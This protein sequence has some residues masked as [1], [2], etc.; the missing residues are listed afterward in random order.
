MSP[1]WFLVVALFLSL[2]VQAQVQK[3]KTTFSD[4]NETEMRHL[5]KALKVHPSEMAQ[6]K[7]VLFEKAAKEIANLETESNTILPNLAK[8][9]WA[10]H[11]PKGFVPQHAKRQVKADLLSRTTATVSCGLRRASETDVLVTLPAGVELEEYTLFQVGWDGEND[12]LYEGTKLVAFDGNDVY[13][14]GLAYYFEDAYVKG[15][16]NAAGQYVFESGQFVG[17]DEY[18]PEYLVGVSVGNDNKLYY[19]TQFV[20]DFNTTT[21]MLSLSEDYLY[22]ESSEKESIHLWDYFELVTYTP[23]AY[24]PPTEVV[25]PT[26]L[27]TEEY[28]ITA[29]NYADD[30][31]IVNTIFIGFEGN[32][33]YLRGMASFLPEA[34]IKGTLNGNTI[35][36]AA[37]QY[38]GSYSNF[39]ESYKLYLNKGK[40]DVVFTYDA[41]AGKLT[42]ENELFLI[43]DGINYYDAYRHAVIT[44]TPFVPIT[45]PYTADFTKSATFYKFFVIDANDDG[46]TW[47]W[48]P[49]D[50]ANYLY[51]PTNTADDYLVLPIE[52]EANKNYSVTVNASSYTGYPDKFE[53]KVG[54]VGTPE[55]MNMTAIPETLAKV[56]DFTDFTG[57]FATDEAGTWYVAIHVISNP[58]LI[59]FKVKSLTIEEGPDLTAPAAVTNLTATA[60]AEGALEVNIT[61]TAPATAIDGSP[62]SGTEDLYIYRDDVLVKTFENVTPGSSLTW[63]DTDVQDGRNYTYYVVAANE[64]GNGA[65]SEDVA[66]YVG[67]DA[68]DDVE[69]VQ[70]VSLGDNTITMAWDPV[71]TGAN[72]G[73]VNPSTIQYSVV[74]IELNEFWGFPIPVEGVTLGVVTGK[75]TAIVNYPV[76]EGEQDFGYFGVKATIGNHDSDP[77]SWF[78]Y[79]IIGA[80][81]ELPLEESF[82]NATSHYLW[83]YNEF[84]ELKGIADGSDDDTALALVAAM[85]GSVAAESGKL[86]LKPAANATLLFDAKKGTSTTDKIT[87][88]SIL[89]DGTTTDIETVI[90]TDEY[91]TYKVVLPTELKN[92]RWV[93]L[94]F[95]ADVEEANKYVVIDNIKVLDFLEHDLSVSLNAPVSVVAGDKVAVTAT[96]KNEGEM[97]ASGYTVTVKA[98]EEVLL[99]ETVTEELASFKTKN[100]IAELETTVFDDAADINVT[101]SVAYDKDLKADNNLAETTISVK[102]PS[103]MGVTNV[104]AESIADGGLLVAWIAPDIDGALVEEMVEDFEEDAGGWTFIDADGDGHNW[105]H[106]IDYVTDNYLIP[107]H[108]DSKGTVHSASYS[109]VWGVLTPD[110]WLVSPEAILNGTFKFWAAGVDP[111]W[112]A[113]HFQVYV[114]TESATDVST[115]KPVS[116]EFIATG[117]YTEYAVDLMDYAGATGWIA[118]RHY[119]SKNEFELV[120]DDITYLP[121]SGIFE[122]DHFNVYLDGKLATTAKADEATATLEGVEKG[123]HTVAVSVVYTNG[124]ESKPA[125]ASVTTDLKSI[126]VITQPVDVYSLEGKLIRRQTTTFDGLKGVYI[127]GGKK[128]VLK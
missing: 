43:N 91:K 23:G 125:E 76:D 108:N 4:K 72:G 41:D 28:E 116:D 31:D 111:D 84:T 14:Q 20:F 105:E 57:A 124:K 80:P 99:A 42:A 68:P 97:T 104:T 126:T 39:F 119:N 29:R 8:W 98:G 10:A 22:G 51:H 118:I 7:Q 56:S 114:S 12:I 86:N 58:D 50:Y 112:S 102:E 107:G 64:S 89:P 122:V 21:R 127:V 94:G 100:F 59:R 101:V 52:L 93:R 53:V 36:F 26:G 47:T 9:D 65:K 79:A 63:Q 66:V 17:E 83:D 70:V 38:L 115:F 48:T 69:N 3:Q 67:Q 45:A 6:Q 5:K 92:E 2:P 16:L 81:Y 1:L 88:F 35:T 15:T 121:S 30:D 74:T 85:A 109:S 77:T 60:G 24:A 54:K 40:A 95:K 117:E 96:V 73:Y 25:P 18:G 34:W 71:T 44:K 19:A 78:A 55:G 49:T 110:N 103:V 113:E 106:H 11:A 27:V 37:G 13:V 33:V 128:V 46:K 32:D 90:L 61:L 123:T 120:V 75:T 82:T 62:L 87:V